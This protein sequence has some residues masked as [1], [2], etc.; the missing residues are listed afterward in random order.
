MPTHRNG[1][2]AGSAGATDRDADELIAPVHAYDLLGY[3]AAVGVEQP[4]ARAAVRSI[5]RGFG[6]VDL[7][8]DFPRYDLADTARG[9]QVRV[10]GAVVQPD[11]DFA[12]ALGAL[13]WHLVTAALGHRDDLFHLHGASLCA[14]LQRAGIVLV[15]ASGKG[16]T[17]LTLGL[18]LRGFVPF[19]DDIALI[20]PE[21]LELQTLRRAFHVAEDTSRLLEPLA[22]GEVRWDTDG[23]ADYLS[24]PQWAERAAPVRWLLFV[25]YRPGHSPQLVPLSP[26]ESATAILTQTLSL[27]SAPRLA[28]ATCGRLTERVACYRFITGD[29]AASVAI[30]ERL[31]AT[32]PPVSGR[33]L[34]E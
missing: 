16:K 13:E 2:N 15:G 26:A 7:D 20:D 28:L 31:V 27:T 8:P 14:P 22:G 19:G 21:T 18:M 9:W 32:P 5:L 23:P 1:A 24:P 29:L 11:A 10:D 12:I 17:T 3:R 25:D 33:D 34:R 4:D 6:P 30:L